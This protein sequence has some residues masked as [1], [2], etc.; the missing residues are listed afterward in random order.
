MFHQ[1][2]AIHKENNTARD[3]IYP[4]YPNKSVSYSTKA[5][6]GGK[7]AGVKLTVDE[8][9]TRV[10]FC[11]KF[12]DA[13]NVKE[14]AVEHAEVDFADETVNLEVAAASAASSSP[15][16]GKKRKHEGEAASV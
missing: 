10:I 14:Q 2:Y 11:G 1:V 4:R 12:L 6:A 15:G 9:L 16:P 5:P 13:K 7:G 3:Y 8:L